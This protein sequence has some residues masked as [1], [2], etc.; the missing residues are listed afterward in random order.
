[1][2]KWSLPRGAPGTDKAR[3]RCVNC[4]L[5]VLIIAGAALLRLLYVNQPFVDAASWR[6]AD[7]ATIADS[8]FR[9]HLNIF[10]PEISWN[11]A[12]SNYVGYEFQLT[13]YLAALL[14]HIFGQADWVGRG[15]SVAFGLWGIFAL[16][17]LVLRAFDAE[18]ALVSSAVFAVNRT[19]GFHMMDHR[20]WAHGR[21]SCVGGQ[22]RHAP[23]PD[24]I[25]AVHPVDSPDRPLAVEDVEVVV[26]PVAALAGHAGAAKDEGHQVPSSANR[27]I[28][29][30]AG[31]LTLS[32]ALLRPER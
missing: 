31:Y 27:S 1:M 18:R 5:L 17:N 2:I 32:Q 12:G 10:L 9:G 4:G 28:A 6:E 23:E 25:R 13:T 7:D 19:D 21:S 29:G 15:I 8:F 14:Y 24:F 20:A 26:V 30:L 11:G 22:E 3:K 16:Y